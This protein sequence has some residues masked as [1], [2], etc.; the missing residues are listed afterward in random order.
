MLRTRRRL[1][2]SKVAPY[3]STSP[4][5]IESRNIFQSLMDSRFIKGDVRILDKYPN[6][7]G[8]L[9]ITDEQQY[10]IGRIDI[11]I[12][13]LRPKNSLNPC[14][15][16]ERSL[17]A[18]S[19]QSSIPVILVVVDRKNKKAYWRHIDND[20]LIEVAGHL[21][22]KSYNLKVPIANCIDG[23]NT[24][25]IRTWTQI[26]KD[27][28]DKVW[29]YDSLQKRNK[30]LEIRIEKLETKFQRP[31]SLPLPILKNIHQFIDIYNYILD[32]EFPTIK[33]VLYPYYWKIGIGILKY[34]PGDIRF[35]LYPVEFK[36]D[37]T[38]VKEVR[39]QDYPDLDR[40]MMEGNVLLLANLNTSDEIKNSP[41]AYA[42]RLL[43]SSI[44]RVAGN[45]N[46][47]IADD[48]I[49]HEYLV[50]F[51]DR[52]HSYLGIDMNADSYDI[53]ELKY[54]LFK[55]IPMVFATD[56]SRGFADW[57]VECDN[58]IDSYVS[59]QTSQKE[60][61]DAIKKINEGFTPR[62][63]VTVTSELY[64]IDL[65][66]YYIN[67]LELAGVARA[68]RKFKRGQRDEKMFGVELWKTWN[69]EV[70]WFNLKLFV[71]NY[72]RLCKKYLNTHFRQIKPALRILPRNETTV[73]YVMHFDE[74]H[75][76]M[77]FLE[78]YFLRPVKPQ[79]G[80]IFSFLVEDP[81]NPID[82]KNMFS[83]DRYDFIID[84]TEYRTISMRVQTLDFMF[85]YS[86]TYALI[87]E[88]VAEA[89]K[90]FLRKGAR[91]SI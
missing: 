4:A 58:N 5:E 81:N 31:T 40:E 70:L 65:I 35:L 27:V 36:K 42:Y 43:E 19:E 12:K 86:P 2:G 57:V 46:F 8:I 49:A 32:R 1:V 60:I 3:P 22:G 10:P 59:H 66:A 30:E 83:E 48:F 26:A 80:K 91:K 7:D 77:P 24:D 55:V 68:E 53:K 73:A 13:T 50:S 6:S 28:I 29:N 41:K 62:V 39:I 74:M 85:K 52:Y 47:P 20:T 44:L 89:V 56:P 75:R 34:E 14:F 67:R 9:E 25:Y 38:L 88:R 45:Y 23:K 54:K 63:K 11:Q 17:F 72:H 79:M 61:D 64:N 84:G 33:Q 37:Q 71:N 82:R 76:S 18:H 78:Q 69:K 90:A 16:C 51:I 21:K 15:Q 87:N